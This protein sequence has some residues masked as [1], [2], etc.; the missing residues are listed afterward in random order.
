MDME[1]CRLCLC[2]TKGTKHFMLEDK[3]QSALQRVFS[4]EEMVEES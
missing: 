3:N 4:L 2:Q 1:D